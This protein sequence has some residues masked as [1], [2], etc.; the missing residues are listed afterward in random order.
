MHYYQFN[1]GDYASHTRYLTPMQ[2]LAYRRLIDLYYLQEKP[3]PVDN[4][5]VLIGLNDFLTDVQQVL[6]TYFI[7]SEQGWVNKRVEQ[8]IHAYKNNIKHK[9]EA[10]K[11]S[12]ASR[13]ANKDKPFE[14]VLN[15]S[16]TDVQLT[17]NHK[18]IT[19]NHK[20]NKLHTPEGVMQSV[21]DDFVA[22]RKAKKAAITQTA[23]KGIEREAK[24]ANISLNDALQEICARGWTGFKAEWMAKDTGET[25]YQKSMRE[26]VEELAPMAARKLQRPFNPNF[27]EDIQNVITDASN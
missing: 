5:A 6:N 25:A 17:N 23:I 15:S 7:L 18:P 21:W 9:S 27:I 10:G 3:I 13:K 22:Q 1:I 12:A 11:K 16:S 4:P 14:Q 2:D 19:N 26:R 24:K 8:E 20:L